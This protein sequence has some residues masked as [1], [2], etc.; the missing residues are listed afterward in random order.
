MKSRILFSACFAIQIMGTAQ[1]L[2]SIESAEFDAVNHR[3][4][5]SNGNDV[6]EVSSTG[7][8]IGPIGGGTP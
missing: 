3:F 6:I 1:T 8:A 7:S 2:S 4:L 5:V